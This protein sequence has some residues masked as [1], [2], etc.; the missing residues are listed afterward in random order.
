MRAFFA[1]ISDTGGGSASSAMT[2]ATAAAGAGPNV[3]ARAVAMGESLLSTEDH[4][5]AGGEGTRVGSPYTGVTTGTDNSFSVGAAVTGE[6]DSAA[7]VAAT[8]VGVR[9]DQDIP[10]QHICPLVQ[11]PPFD[12]IHF[13]V[14]SAN[15]TTTTPTSQQVYEKSALYRFVGMQGDLSIRRTLTHPFNRVRIARNLAWDCVRPVAPA[16]QETL[17]RERSVLGLLLE[18]NNPLNDND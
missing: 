13:D 2:A 11:E 16:L 7:A 1:A 17:H 14:P 18:D 12:A 3:Y 5:S 4:S 10:S 9:E 15:G 8:G 6:G